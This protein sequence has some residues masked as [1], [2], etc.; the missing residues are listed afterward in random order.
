M[1]RCGGRRVGC[2]STNARSSSAIL[3]SIPSIG[4]D[5]CLFCCSTIEWYLET[6]SSTEP[7]TAANDGLRDPAPAWLTSMPMTIVDTEPRDSLS[8]PRPAMQLMPPSLRLTLSIK[9]AWYC[10][11][12]AM[13]LPPPP[14]PLPPPPLPLPPPLATSALLIWIHCDG[15]PETVCDQRFMAAYVGVFAPCESPIAHTS[16]PTFRSR[17]PDARS[18]SCSIVSRRS[19]LV[20]PS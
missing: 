13:G 14:L 15:M 12:S 2:F 3:P 7:T 18:S 11:S 1:M 5:F 9:P 4:S 20:S 8:P 10:A 16:S 19:Y 6:S 17:G